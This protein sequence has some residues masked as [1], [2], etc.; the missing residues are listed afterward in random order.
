GLVRTAPVAERTSSGA[1][2]LGSN[3]SICDG[4]PASQT[5]TTEVA[6]ADLEVGTPTS[7]ACSRWW[8]ERPPS[9]SAPTRK[10]SRRDVPSHVIP[11]R[12]D[13]KVNVAGQRWNW[14]LKVVISVPTYGGVTVRGGVG[15]LKG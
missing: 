14:G 13:R 3:V 15:R 11:R 7:R 4:P 5:Q 9:P 1:L 2:G 6:F 10:K 8:R 12:D